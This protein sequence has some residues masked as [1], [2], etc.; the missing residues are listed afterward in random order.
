MLW[1]ETTVSHSE[2][3]DYFI[4]FWYIE[5]QVWHCMM[6]ILM[7]SLPVNL[8]LDCFEQRVVS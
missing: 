2:F 4:L 6:T 5:L 8:K 7:I 1:N 3:S